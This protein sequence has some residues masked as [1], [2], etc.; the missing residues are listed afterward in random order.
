MRSRLF[1]QRDVRLIALAELVAQSRGKLET[2]RAAADDDDSMQRPAARRSASRIHRRLNRSDFSSR[3]LSS[4]WSL[5][6]RHYA[7]LAAMC[8][9]VAT[10][11]LSGSS[12][13]ASAS[14]F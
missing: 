2:A 9:S 11:T 8:A 12:P 6:V 10:S 5:E 1:D 4:Q 13:S 3:G 14:L 7:A